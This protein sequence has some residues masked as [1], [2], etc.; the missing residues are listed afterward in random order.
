[1]SGCL[2]KEGAGASFQEG[3][4]GGLDIRKEVQEGSGGPQLL[5]LRKEGAG[6]PD[7]FLPG[8]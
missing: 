1:M 7:S 6:V 8:S 4:T 3:E 5:G 2:G